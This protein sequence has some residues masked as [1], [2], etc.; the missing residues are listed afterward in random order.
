VEFLNYHHLRYFWMVAREGSLRKAAERLNVSQPT[1]SAQIASLESALG[2]RLFRRSPRGLS[3]TETGQEALSYA[4]EI[5]G[6]GQE[7]L[8]SLK[9]RPGQRPLRVHIGI[10]DSLPKLVSHEIIKPIF[11]LN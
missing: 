11:T 3:L 7:F 6:L 10:S 2:E 1:I 9:Q 5:F 8:Q 4:E